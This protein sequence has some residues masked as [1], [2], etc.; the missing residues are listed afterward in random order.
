MDSEP[1]DFPRCMLAGRE[2][3]RLPELSFVAIERA[4][5]ENADYLVMWY[6]VEDRPSAQD[7]RSPH[8]SRFARR[9][10]QLRTRTAQ[11]RPA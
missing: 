1:M 6:P 8:Q 9:H 10:A 2:D 4:R 3:E 7:L 5:R 11:Q